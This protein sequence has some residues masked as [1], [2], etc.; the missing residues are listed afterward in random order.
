MAKS[1]QPFF[2]TLREAEDWGLR[3]G[4]RWGFMY[5][6][7]KEAPQGFSKPW[8]TK[9]GPK[10]FWVKITKGKRRGEQY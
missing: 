1:P 4:N 8:M 10:G 5:K 7:T 9:K 6:P 3:L 2:K